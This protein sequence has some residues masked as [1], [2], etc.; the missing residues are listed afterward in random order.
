MKYAKTDST[1]TSLIRDIQANEPTAWDEFAEVYSPI[2]MSF[3]RHQLHSHQDSL[4][5]LQEC[6]I[7]VNG[8]I[9]RFD[10]ECVNG[11]F[12]S[13]LWTIV[14]R[15]LR[16]FL[17]KSRRDRKYLG[18][19]SSSEGL[20]DISGVVESEWNEHFIQ[21]LIRVSMQRIKHEFS[22]DQWFAFE[23]T[24]MDQKRPADVAAS[25][26]QTAGWVYKS[27]FQCLKRLEAEIQQLSDDLPL[28]D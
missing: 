27:K 19:K 16:R 4:D 17:E 23:Q 1:N 20:D 13:W 26:H 7:A 25:L 10:P 24:W 21:A 3:V 18:T 12:R 5:V 9:A 8:S 15:V 11:R 28:N 6:L 22:A 2:I 14:W